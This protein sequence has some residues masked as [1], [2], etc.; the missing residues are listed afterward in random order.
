MMPSM[1]VARHRACAS[2]V[3][4]AA[5]L[6]LTGTSIAASAENSANSGSQAVVSAPSSYA[7]VA[8]FAA[9]SALIIDAR[10][11]RARPL[12][13]GSVPGLPPQFVRMAVDADVT[14]LIFGSDSVG[15]RIAYLVDV[16]RTADGRS[17][18]IN[19]QRVLLFARPIAAAGQLQLVAPTAQLAWDGGRDTTVRAIA[20]ER[21]A[22]PSPPAISGVGQ[23]FH[24]P[25]TIAGEGETQIFLRTPGGDPVSLTILRRPD[26]EPRW[27]V[28]FGEIVD[29]SAS[30]PRRRTL[31][32]YRLACGLP[33]TLPDTAIAGLTAD[34]AQIAAQDYQIVRRSLGPCDATPGGPAS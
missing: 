12:P 5:I 15:G 13:D 14:T 25:G 21:A 18:H 26:Q 31:A 2:R 17:P 10:I 1:S 16:R 32:W 20:A 34:D 23:A 27:A 7:D 24:V 6:L 4:L 9:D 30:T 19:R 29:E 22:A 3:V 11:R 28:A 8:R 33:P